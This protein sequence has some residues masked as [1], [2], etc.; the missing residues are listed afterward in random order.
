MPGLNA[1]LYLGL[2]SLQ[3]QQSALNVVGQN[4]A[5]VNTPGYSRQR[6]DLTSNR[7]VSDGQLFFGTG[8][9]LT[10]VQGIRDRF[11][12]LQIY[13]ETAKQSGASDRADGV[14]AV[15]ASLGD[16]SNTGIGAQIQAFF[17]GMQDL[18]AQPESSAL[19]TN[20]ISKAQGMISSMQARY[21]LLDGQR[22]SADQ[23]VGSLVNDVNSL[24]SQIAQLNNQIMT[25]TSPGASNDA[26]DQRKALTD[27]LSALIGI[28]VVE[29]TRGDYQI[30]LDSGKATLVSGSSAFQLQTSRSA[31]LDGHLEVDAVFGGTT[32]A[33]SY[34]DITQGQLGA[35]LDLRDHILVGFQQQLD[36]LAAGIS[37]QVNLQH[38]TGYGTD[39][40][41]PLNTG[42][43]FFQG[44][45][46]NLADG[47][48]DPALS[49]VGPPDYKGMVSALS[50]NSAILSNTKLIAA[51]GAA[52]AVGDNANVNAMANL[53][54]SESTLPGAMVLGSTFSAAVGSLVS[55]V[56]N[57]SQTLA[58]QTTAQQNLVLALQ[59]Q[60]D[61]VSGVNLDE[62]AANMLT[63]QRGYQAAGRFLSV[64]NQ[65]TDQLVNQFAQ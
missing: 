59:A 33:L 29:G 44:S 22:N 8:V 23:A 64:I 41:N 30:S 36:K 58:T 6:A 26:R 60:R 28:N 15:A 49:Q 57:Q 12:D 4:I 47:L 37:S 25:E 3:A 55:D 31:A 56:G 53:Q 11:L 35:K 46:S 10:S 34:Q 24:T 51:A 39:P 9:S 52:G 40:T 17:Q 20:L 32:T 14:N 45:V 62:E 16:T 50:V 5:N 61:S 48:P 54:F 63:L 42:I 27:K 43:D 38:R 2:S 21:Q 1:S 13:R 7:A 65:L 18:A 19:R